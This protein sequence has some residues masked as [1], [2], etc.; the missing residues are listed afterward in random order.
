MK[1]TDLSLIFIG[2]MLPIIIVVYINVS[3]TIKAEE[4]EMYYEKLITSAVED[5]ANRMKE[6]ENNDSE[7][8]YGYSGQT[9][10]KVSVNAQIGVDSFFN[11]LYN[12][13]GI[14]GNE[15]AQHYLQLYVPA[16]A[17]IDYNGF[18]ISSMETFNERINGQMQSVTK[19]VL[20]P[21]RYFTYS[22]YL[23]KDISTYRVV[24]V[25]EVNV[26]PANTISKHTVEFTMDDYITHRGSEK[27][28]STWKNLEVK[29][30]YIA[31]RK[32]NFDISAGANTYSLD[33][34]DFDY[35]ANDMVVKHLLEARKQVIAD[36]VMKEMAYATN[37]NNAYA[38]SVGVTYEFHFPTISMTDW[39]DNVEHIG[40]IAF[41][42]GI[43]VGNKYLN[44][45]AVGLSKLDLST[46]YY[47][48]TPINGQSKY[49]I[50][51]Y[52]KDDS[53]P[54]Y[55]ISN[56]DDIIP[57]YVLTKQQAASALAYDVL[58]NR[59]VT[60]GFYPCS[61]CRP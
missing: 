18:Q 24:P 9:D 35:R 33:T 6:V 2:I 53:C 52:H 30:F 46:R 22:Y 47:L 23:V 56:H 49:N 54:E 7:L 34:E 12:N 27:V 15:S 45:K 19:H 25:N 61:I 10:K 5:G 43:S 31:D 50:P 28:G 44:T 48:T 14:K 37:A 13:F 11:S 26:M 21:K 1:L 38:R 58:K 60:E 55:Q 51:L 41:V 36:T 29:S 40:M 59:K 16:I 4:Q 42:Q 3:Y 32:N 39:Y 57:K 17:V 8:D 20:K